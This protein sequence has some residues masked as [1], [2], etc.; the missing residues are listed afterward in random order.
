VLVLLA[1]L[2]WFLVR[3]RLRPLDRIGE[4]ADAIAAGDLSRRVEVA[5]PK[6]EV[7]RVGLAIVAGIVAVHRG[8]VRA[9]NAR[10]GGA[11]FVIRLPL[12]D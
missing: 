10:G 3:T 8:S 11:S 7:G 12:A 4:T 2:S 5:T 9:A 1:L 6:T